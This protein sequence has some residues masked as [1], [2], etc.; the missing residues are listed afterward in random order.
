[1]QTDSLLARIDE[2]V[3][4]E[5]AGPERAGELLL[6][7]TS[8]CSMLYGPDSPQVR[9]IDAAR[10]DVWASKYAE[11][12]KY[13]LIG[14]QLEG[15]LRAVASD[16]RGGRL[17]RLALESAG[18]VFGDFLTASRAA[19]SEGQKPVAAVLACAALEDALKR[20]A[21]DQGLEVFDK[22]MSEVVNALKGAGKVR[23]PQASLL[24]GFV[25]IR[26]KAFHAQWEAIDTADVQSVVGFTQEFLLK[27]FSPGP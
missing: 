16:I 20:F 19:L 15:I 5:T 13:M 17:R 25:R 10:K 9:A 27:N 7:A 11:T 24:S 8:F 26:N 3:T 23:G 1:M 14:Q 12:M 4:G 2:L 6:A 18:E 21:A 22:D